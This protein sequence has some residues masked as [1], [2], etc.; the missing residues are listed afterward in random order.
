MTYEAAVSELENILQEL[1]EGQVSMDALNE[2]VARAEALIAWCRQRLRNVE[3]QLD[4]LDN[5]N[6]K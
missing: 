1:Q 2:K 3:A 6:N 4:Q 5:T